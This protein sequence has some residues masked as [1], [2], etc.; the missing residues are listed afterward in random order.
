MASD[1]YKTSLEI[2]F[3]PRQDKGLRFFFGDVYNGTITKK[4]Y[5]VCGRCCDGIFFAWI[6]L[7][8]QYRL[9]ASP[10]NHKFGLKHFGEFSHP[11]NR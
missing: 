2:K 4:Y 11:L 3:L 6:N 10:N 1:L 5:V 9:K 7:P 8:M